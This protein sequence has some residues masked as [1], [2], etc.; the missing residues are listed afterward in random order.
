M[1]TVGW[2]SSAGS[3]RASRRS[4]D[5]NDIILRHLPETCLPDAGQG[6]ESAMVTDGEDQVWWT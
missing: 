4:A 2:P 5:N 3:L 6:R 1:I